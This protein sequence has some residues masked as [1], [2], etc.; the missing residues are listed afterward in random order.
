LTAVV[1]Y[2]IDLRVGAKEYS[3]NVIHKRADHTSEPINKLAS[4]L[5]L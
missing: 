4:H 1:A 3:V 5:I 2:M